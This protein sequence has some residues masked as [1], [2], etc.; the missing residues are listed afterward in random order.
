MR[1]LKLC[2]TGETPTQR[3]F[4]CDA[5]R[6]KWGYM[7]TGKQKRYLRG[8]GHSL[9]PVVTIGKGEISEAVCEETT[10][11]LDFHE[12]IKV[13]ILESC[14]T[15]RHEIADSLAQE[16]SAEVVQVLGRTILLYKKGREPKIE[17]P[18]ADK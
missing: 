12:L 14:L 18:K 5:V 1:D 13:K 17:L 10:A 4:A 11:A 15:D 16:C 7:L 3:I 2:R 8:L 6:R 9:K